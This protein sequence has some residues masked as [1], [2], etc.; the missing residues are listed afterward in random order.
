MKRALIIDDSQDFRNSMKALLETNR[1][2]VTCAENGE[3]GFSAAI[4]QKH[5]LIVLDVMMENSDTGLNTV[6]R[7]RDEEST[8]DIP[9]FL[10]T[11]I[12]KPQF[13]LSSYAPD[14]TFRNV[15][16]VFEKPVDP[17]LFE[18]ALAEVTYA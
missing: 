16:E 6:R 1:Y 13:L 10:V 18:K 17:V 14:E 8:R 3:S 5:D 2:E 7:F 15:K 11:G 12:H 4:A 9:V